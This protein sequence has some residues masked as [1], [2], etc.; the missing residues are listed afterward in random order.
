MATDIALERLWLGQCGLPN[1]QI[2]AIKQALPNCKVNAKGSSSTGNGW[3]EHRRYRTLKEMY[4]T[5]SF[6]PFT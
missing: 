1:S 5:G 4:K 6:I 2:N 3:R